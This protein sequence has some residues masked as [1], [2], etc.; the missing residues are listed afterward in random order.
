MDVNIMLSVKGFINAI[1]E[2]NPE[3]LVLEAASLRPFTF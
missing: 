2:L 1:S 3:A